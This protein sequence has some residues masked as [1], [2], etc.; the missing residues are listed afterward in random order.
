MNA[1]DARKGHLTYKLN[2]KK[3]PVIPYFDPSLIFPYHLLP[4]P[5]HP[6]GFSF[7]II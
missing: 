3:V 4:A 7:Y 2:S 5:M 1:G 6:T